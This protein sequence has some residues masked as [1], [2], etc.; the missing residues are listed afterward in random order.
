MTYAIIEE[1]DDIIH[2]QTVDVSYTQQDID[3]L[4]NY[5]IK[6]V[7]TDTY[8]AKIRRYRTIFPLKDKDLKLIV[9][10]LYSNR[11]S[12]ITTRNKIKRQLHILHLLYILLNEIYYIENLS[13]CVSK[14]EFQTH[15]I[16]PSIYLVLVKYFIDS[17]A[18]IRKLI[19]TQYRKFQKHSEDSIRAYLLLFKVDKKIIHHD[20]I[21]N[22]IFNII[23]NWDPA[24]IKNIDDFYTEQVQQLM[25]QYLKHKLE[26]VVN[27]DLTLSA[28]QQ[29]ISLHDV[30]DRYYIYKTGFN[31]YN[32]NSMCKVSETSRCITQNF[33]KLQNILTDNELQKMFLKYAKID[34]SG[35]THKNV[36]LQV[37]ECLLN[38]KELREKY[39][40]VYK[41]L[42]CVCIKSDQLQI[43]PKLYEFLKN[44]V[45]TVFFKKFN[46]L[47]RNE[48]L[49]EF[50]KTLSTNFANS[51]SYN[52][53][54]DPV[55][56]RLFVITMPLVRQI[57]CFLEDIL[58]VDVKGVK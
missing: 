38:M 29:E 45:Q 39:P 49:N 57:C 33:S 27:H 37:H 46:T 48:L 43:S 14:E 11:I 22:F 44:T 7:I 55:D 9:D 19:Q 8:L 18:F 56:M 26:G 15:F 42:Q 13:Q 30:S 52:R 51:I 12:A 54:L 40:L 32:L 10:K 1:S 17:S 23:P 34:P 41:F 36:L 16:K 47:V 2:D 53:Y 20:I 31:M 21:Y 50:V 3:L 58:T 5:I 24:V 35:L 6:Y 4:Y 25:Y 28:L